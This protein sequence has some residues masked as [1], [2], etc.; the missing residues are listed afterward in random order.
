M[1]VPVVEVESDVESV[2]SHEAAQALL[3]TYLGL[4]P[5]AQTSVTVLLHVPLIHVAPDSAVR[6]HDYMRRQVET[7]FTSRR[8]HFRSMSHYW[9][10]NLSKP[11]DRE[12]FVHVA[13]WTIRAELYVRGWPGAFA[14]E[15]ED[16][17]EWFSFSMPRPVYADFFDAIDP[18]A[19][20]SEWPAPE[21]AGI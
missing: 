21:R 15:S 13:F 20:P 7:A 1:R 12:A 10:S 18:S 6:A 14:F 19:R 11:A 5:A 9:R 3:R 16:S 4:L 17:G 8:V 2:G